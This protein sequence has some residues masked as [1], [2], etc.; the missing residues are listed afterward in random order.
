M[1]P[2]VSGVRNVAVSGAASI[3][4]THVSKTDMVKAALG[5]CGS[6]V[7][8]SV[9]SGCNS[10]YSYV[11]GNANFAFLDTAIKA[12]GLVS[13]L[14]DPALVATVFAPTDAGFTST[15]AALNITPQELFDDVNALT[16][17]LKYHVIPG[18]SLEKRDFRDG[19]LYDTLLT[20][21]KHKKYQ[22]QFNYDK[23][24]D[25]T[26]LKA[27][28]ELASAVTPIYQIIPSGGKAAKIT[29][30]DINAGCPSV[31]HVINGVL[32]PAYQ[33]SLGVDVLDTALDAVTSAQVAGV[34]T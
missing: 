32:I 7:A 2:Q 5:L 22:V 24:I 31:V 20:D 29:T 17:I 30:F 27:S 9:P 13:V 14:D 3:Q 28:G 18:L 34:R 11:R 16:V 19:Q 1:A 6:Y 23:Q 15:L 26:S 4:P 12:T 25:I 8:T 21:S 10:V 33:D